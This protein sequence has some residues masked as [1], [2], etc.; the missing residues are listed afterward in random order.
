MGDSSSRPPKNEDKAS[1]QTRSKRLQLR[2]WNLF[3]HLSNNG[4]QT[5]STGAYGRL[6]EGETTDRDAGTSQTRHKTY[7]TIAVQ[8]EDVSETTES[9]AQVTPTMTTV[10]TQTADDSTGG[11]T[12][13]LDSLI[14]M[15]A[16]KRTKSLALGLRELTNI[17][18][19]CNKGE[20]KG[21]ITNRPIPNMSLFIPVVYFG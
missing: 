4:T 12:I 1:S 6:K 17:H 3:G 10:E 8:T 13:S 9:A 20:I 16:I 5:A 21:N 14:R 18:L 19:H 2:P 15:G 7:K 11:T